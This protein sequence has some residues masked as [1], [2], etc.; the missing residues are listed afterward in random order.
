MKPFRLTMIFPALGHRPGEHYNRA[1]QMEPL[2]IATVAGLTPSDIELRFFDDRMES[3]DTDAPCDAVAISVETYTA[4]RAYSIAELYRKRGIPVI[5][6]GFHATLAPDDV[7][8]HA[9]AVII[10]EAEEVWGR[11]LE[12]LRCGTLAPGYRAS[13][14]TSLEKIKTNRAIFAGRKY[15]PVTLVET[16]RGCCYSCDFCCIGAFFAS[17]RRQR[18]LEATMKDI[19]ALKDQARLFFFVDDHFAAD[20][21]AAAEL[22][23]QIRGLG[24]RWVSQMS[25]PAALDEDFVALMRESGCT[26]ILTGIESLD[27]KNLACMNKS[28]NASA[29]T[30]ALKNLKRHKISVYPT[31]VFGYDWDVRESF[32][33]AVDFAIK[34]GFYVAAFKHLMPFPGTPLYERLKTEGRLRYDAWW[35]DENYRYSDLAFFPKTLAPEDISRGC[36]DARRRFYS[37]TNI[38]RRMNR[39]NLSDFFK[40]RNYLPINLMHRWDVMAWDGQPLG[41][42]RTAQDRS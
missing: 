6:G 34:H 3:V 1:W 41:L 30:Q 37:W 2:P 33:I 16:G 11:M 12:D 14:V 26:G 40:L 29:R 35:L 17:T 20:P 4:K 21:S 42:E 27:E 25:L 18:P 31:F 28:F 22:M 36:S 32:D 9:D 15:L 8:N 39:E 7:A 19:L 24:I 38:I 23:R 5:M 10:G 13:A